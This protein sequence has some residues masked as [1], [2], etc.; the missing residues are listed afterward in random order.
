MQTKKDTAGTASEQQ[1]PNFH[2]EIKNK[3]CRFRCLVSIPA[4]P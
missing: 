2:L 1:T 4:A 3:K